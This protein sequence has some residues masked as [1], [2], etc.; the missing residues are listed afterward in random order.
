MLFFR[1]DIIISSPI[2]ILPISNTSTNVLIA[3]LG[4]ISCSNA[5]KC[6]S[7]E[8]NESYTIEIKNTYVYSLNIDEGEYSFNV[9]PAK[10]KDAIPIL[11]DTAITLQLYAGYSDDNDEDKQLNRFSVSSNYN[12]L[13]CN[14]FK[15]FN[16]IQ[17]QIKGSMVE[18]L[19]VSLNRKQYELLLESIR[20]ATNFS[21][22]VLNESDELDQNGD[23]EPTANI[24]A[25][26][27][28]S[29]T[30]QFSVPV[31]QINLQN[32]YHNDLINLT[33]KNFNVKHISKGFDKD[34]EVVLKS[35]LMEDLKSDLTSPFRN[36]VTSVDL[37]QKIKKNEMTS[38]SCPDLPSYCNSLK[39]RSSS[40]PS[41]FY[42]HMQVKVFGG[43]QKYTSSN[44]NELGKK[45]ESQTLVIY[46]SHTGR[47]AQNGKL[48]QTSS[49]QFN[50]LNLAICV[51]R[52]YTIFD[53]FG[54][55]S[56]D[57]V[58]EKYPEEMKLVEKRECL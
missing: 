57:N 40:V 17:S 47:S 28:I 33:F 6:D 36:M 49:I 41:C 8:F 11:H 18:A 20:Y 44:K 53:F 38:S 3:N 4:K 25:E 39:N 13:Y 51:E 55:V 15:Y 30:I 19:K 24:D 5:V 56:V 58:N 22:E 34:V 14:I 9:H 48:E 21:N 37:E 29:T 12:S 16:F 32:E 23:I 46:K 31:F 1:L 26:S 7:D 10:N 27:I 52:W 50:C 43:D 2:I 45:K 42:N 54:L 35:V